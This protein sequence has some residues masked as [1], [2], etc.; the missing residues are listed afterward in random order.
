MYHVEIFAP[1]MTVKSLTRVRNQ[2]FIVEHLYAVVQTD[3]SPL[4]FDTQTTGL[5]TDAEVQQRGMGFRDTRTDVIRYGTEEH[6]RAKQSTARVNVS[7]LG[8]ENRAFIGQNTWTL[9]SSPHSNVQCP[10]SAFRSRSYN[11]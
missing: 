6:S 5:S 3:A 8:T 2:A 11:R 4:R 7:F 1:G 9:P 10:M